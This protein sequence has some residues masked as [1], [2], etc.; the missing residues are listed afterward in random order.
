MKIFMY[1][2]CQ[3]IVSWR[4]WY[5]IAMQTIWSAYARSKIGQFWIT[6]LFLIFVT[7]LGIIYTKLW[8]TEIN[9][10]LPFFALSHM[11]WLFMSTIILESSTVYVAN[12]GYLKAQY[13]PKTIFI[14]SVIFKNFV[15]M[16][17]NSLVVILAFLYFLKPIYWTAVFALPGLL[18]LVLNLYWMALM[19]ALI[20]ARF[21]DIPAVVT[22]AVQIIFFVSPILWPPSTIKNPEIRFILVDLNPVANLMSLIRDPLLGLIPS[23]HTYIYT[24]SLMLIGLGLTGFVFTKSHNRLVYWI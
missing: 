2:T 14:L 11:I 24:L 5:L 12:A 1:D 21:R 6:L 3:S 23:M 13:Q 10:F 7:S 16:A 9:E 20:C 15:V 4:K 22:S 17:H 19:N 8:Q 18:I